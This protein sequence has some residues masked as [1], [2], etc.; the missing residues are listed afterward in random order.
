MDELE[1]IYWR[2]Q[3][4]RH[5]GD[6]EVYAIHEVYFYRGGGV[7]GYTTDSLS[8][9][10]PTIVNLK[11]ELESFLKSE[12]E[13]IQCGDQNYTYDKAD[14]EFW[15]KHINDPVLEYEDEPE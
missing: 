9:R 8:D 10:Y 14:V 7:A 13:S 12:L 4:M 2:P 11:S 3:V 5:S 6:R 15:L 1:D